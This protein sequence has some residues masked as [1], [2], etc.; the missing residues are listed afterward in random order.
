MEQIKF[1]YQKFWEPGAFQ[2]TH[3]G[4]RKTFRK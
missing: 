4:I 3:I 2:E 1:Q